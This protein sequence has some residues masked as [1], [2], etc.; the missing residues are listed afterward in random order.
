MIY[1]LALLLNSNAPL[2]P[3]VAIRMFS[4]SLIIIFDY[5]ALFSIHFLFANFVCF[6]L[7]LELLVCPNLHCEN[8]GCVVSLVKFLLFTFPINKRPSLSCVC[9]FHLWGVKLLLNLIRAM[10]NLA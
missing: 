8:E 1:T 9:V 10:F 6:S 3:H 4:I 7:Y 5:F 2:V